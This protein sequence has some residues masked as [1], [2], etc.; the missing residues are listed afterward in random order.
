MKL[1]RII[2]NHHQEMISYIK[3]DKLL[4]VSIKKIQRKVLLYQIVEML[5]Y[6]MIR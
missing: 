2:S 3:L 6:K 5:K 4:V 1:L